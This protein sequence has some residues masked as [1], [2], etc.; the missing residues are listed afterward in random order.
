MATTQEHQVTG[1]M[2]TS[3]DAAV[4]DGDEKNAPMSSAVVQAVDHPSVSAETG[5]KLPT[6]IEMNS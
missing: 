2:D 3:A 5:E 6:D 1:S 4:V